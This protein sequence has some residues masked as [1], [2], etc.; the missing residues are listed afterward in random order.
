MNSNF[1]E[2]IKHQVI[3]KLQSP[4]DIA[5]TFIPPKPYDRS[6]RTCQFQVTQKLSLFETRNKIP[7]QKS[8]R[9]YTTPK[10]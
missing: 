9:P 5:A 4:L 10:L 8:C 1:Y 3:N 7:Q 6:L 2:H